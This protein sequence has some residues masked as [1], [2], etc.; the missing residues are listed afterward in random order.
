MEELIVLCGGNPHDRSQPL[1]HLARFLPD[2]AITVGVQRRALK[3]EML[4][5]NSASL[6]YPD[7]IPYVQWNAPDNFDGVAAYV[8]NGAG[9]MYMAQN[10]LVSELDTRTYRQ[11]L[12]NSRASPD[13]VAAQNSLRAIRERVAKQS[14]WL[15]AFYDHG[16]SLP[17]CVCCIDS[18]CCTQT[19]LNILGTNRR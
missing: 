12:E 16:M 6:P 19:S 5:K 8:I 1:T 4:Y 3:V 9:R 2:H 15:F 11:A 10:F 17:F 13:D 7:S 18:C 14:S